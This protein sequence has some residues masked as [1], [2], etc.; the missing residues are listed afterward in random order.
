MLHFATATVHG[1]HIVCRDW[2]I[3]V[4]LTVRHSRHGGSVLE[5]VSL[6]HGHFHVVMILSWRFPRAMVHTGHDHRTVIHARHTRG[7]MILIGHVHRA[8]IHARSRRR[9]A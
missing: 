1:T 5:R 9:R 2:R 4:G 6:L 3:R 8:M 7:A